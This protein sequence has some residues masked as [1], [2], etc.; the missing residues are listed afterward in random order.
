M[1]KSTKKLEEWTIKEFSDYFEGSKHLFGE[2]GSTF[3]EIT[4]LAKDL[5]NNTEELISYNM[6]NNRTQML[7]K[8]IDAA[9]TYADSHANPF[10]STGKEEKVGA[11]ISQRFKITHNGK[12][13]FFTEENYAKKT[14]SVFDDYVKEHHETKEDIILAKNRYFFQE[15]LSDA[16]KKDIVEEI[17]DI[18]FTVLE[19]QLDAAMQEQDRTTKAG[20]ECYQACQEL[21]KNPKAKG[22]MLNL[23]KKEMSFSSAYSIAKFNEKNQ[24][25]LTRK[26]IATSRM[27]ELLGIGTLIAHSEKMIVNVNGKSVSGCFMEFAE[28]VD[29]NNTKEM[30]ELSKISNAS[31]EIGGNFSKD[32]SN[33]Q[34]FDAICSQRDRHSGN[35]FVK[36]GES[37]EKGVRKIVGLQGIDND[38]SFSASTDLDII[39]VSDTKSPISNIKFIDGTFARNVEALTKDKIEYAVGDILNSAE[40]HAL[41]MRIERVK[42]HIKENAIRLETEND[43]KLNKYSADMDISKLDKNEQEYAKKYIHEVNEIKELQTKDFFF[44]ANLHNEGKAAYGFRNGKKK[45]EKMLKEENEL[46]A[47]FS[48]MFEQAEQD[49]KT[50]ENVECV[51]KTRA[52]ERVTFKDL[53]EKKDN[54]LNL[55][56]TRTMHNQNEKKTIVMGVNRSVGKK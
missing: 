21:M 44:Y 7:Q 29:A 14:M 31:V 11:N 18:N 43:W 28:G 37:D 19:K 51:R 2:N 52:K 9:V 8:L 40:I 38:L 39:D 24:T 53:V 10:T 47:D 22:K 54:N 17:S 45:Y 48:K 46:F 27:A 1:A 33:L 32:S 6:V 16:V 15:Y 41:M 36:L 56:P 34:L 13:G 42:T 50:F 4:T 23:W 12:T 5:K 55:K 49:G 20:E 26:N 30:Y 35:F 25:E 3:K